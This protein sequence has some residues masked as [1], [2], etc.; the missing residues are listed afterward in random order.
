M[1]TAAIDIGTNTVLLLIADV[2]GHEKITTITDKIQFPRL[3]IGTQKQGIIRED[4]IDRTISVLLKYKEIAGKN[5]VESIVVCGT[6]AFREAKN[7][8]EVVETIKRRTGFDVEVIDGK[9]E[10]LLSFHGALSGLN[11]PVD[12][13][14]V[15]DIGGGSTE[16]AYLI[17]NEMHTISLLLGA[18][19]LTEIFF[20]AVPATKS[21]ISKA[22]EYIGKELD[23]HKYENIIGRKLIGVAGTPTTLACLDQGLR[24]FGRIAVSSYPMTIAR[25]E[26]WKDKLASLTLSEIRAL[27]RATAGREDII[28]A[29]TFILAEFMRKSKFSD[30]IVSER[31]LRYGLIMRE[32]NR[33][34]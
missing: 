25:I 19:R 8:I 16:I 17:N 12:Q 32:W 11:I 3:G 30:L 2:E 4:A 28:S 5:N 31:G 9:E 26:Y 23:K 27:T 24:D 15:I 6:S 14:V 13:S 1:R 20:D 7:Q 34:A 29:G 33:R 18:V 10:A 21:Q 22:V